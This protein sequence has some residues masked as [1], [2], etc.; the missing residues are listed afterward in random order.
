MERGS[1]FQRNS[2]GM[3]ITDVNGI[4][5]VS[6]SRF[7]LSVTCKLQLASG[8]AVRDPCDKRLVVA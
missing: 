7:L 4:G 2:R 6:T 8:F 3:V 5:T 1:F